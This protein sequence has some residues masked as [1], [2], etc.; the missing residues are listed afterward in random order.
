MKKGQALAAVVVIH[1]AISILHGS[2]HTGAEVPLPLAGTLFVYIVILVG[3]LLGLGV[4]PW[5]PQAGG[6]LVAVSMSGALVFG[7]V[8]HFMIDG[9]DHVANIACLWRTLFDVTAA[10]L[11]ISEAAGAAVGVWVATWAAGKAS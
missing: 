7:V 11:V 9:P 5:L 3:P 6:W 4:W 1:P 2:A 10:L 8:N